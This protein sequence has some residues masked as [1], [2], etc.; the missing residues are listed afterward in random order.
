MNLSFT[1]EIDGK[2]SFFKEKILLSLGTVGL[3]D[4]NPKLHTIRRTRAEATGDPKAPEWQQG[5]VIDFCISTAAGQE[6]PFGPKIRCTGIQNICICAIG[7]S[8]PEIHI[9]GH[10]LDVVQIRELAVNDGFENLEDFLN[11]FQ[12]NFSGL[13]IHWTKKRY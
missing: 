4:L 8:L 3:P 1:A 11:Y 7:N 5:M 9:D 2:P 13:L 6:I 12:G 10:E